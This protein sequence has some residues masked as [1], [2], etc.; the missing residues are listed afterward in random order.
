MIL[1]IFNGDNYDHLVLL[2]DDH[3]VR[4]R[5]SAEEVSAQLTV[6]DVRKLIAA[7]REL[8]RLYPVLQPEIGS[9]E[10]PGRASYLAK[11]YPNLT[12]SVVA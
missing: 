6:K 10:D 9:E 4:I 7:R 5:I 12:T 11:K 2:P 1:D 8:P 3:E